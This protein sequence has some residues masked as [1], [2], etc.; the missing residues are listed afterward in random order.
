MPGVAIG[1]RAI[2]FGGRQAHLT[3]KVKDKA[4][5]EGG[6]DQWECVEIGAL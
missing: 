4:E 3:L 2:G 1:E 6:N 5:R